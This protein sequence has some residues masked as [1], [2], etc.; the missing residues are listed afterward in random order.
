M[1][2]F[3]NPDRWMCLPCGGPRV[4]QAIPGASQEAFLFSGFIISRRSHRCRVEVRGPDLPV[5]LSGSWLEGK[6]VPGVMPMCLF[7]PWNQTLSG[8][9]KHWTGSLGLG[10]GL[11]VISWHGLLCGYFQQAIL[12]S[13]NSGLHIGETRKVYFT[14]LY[15]LVLE[16]MFIH[17]F[18]HSVFLECPLS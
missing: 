16:Y 3:S 6:I 13:H 7:A 8:E 9:L 4:Q 10:F 5:S 1:P 14:F 17:I 18:I 2:P 11:K 12:F 15:M